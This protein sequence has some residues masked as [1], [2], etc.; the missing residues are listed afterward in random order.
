M[1][2]A[3][4]CQTPA[5]LCNLLAGGHCCD[6]LPRCRVCHPARTSEHSAPGGWRSPG[7]R[8][9]ACA[10]GCCREGR[11]RACAPASRGTARARARR[12]WKRAAAPRGFSSSRAS[13]K[14]WELNLFPFTVC[15]PRTL[16]RGSRLRYVKRV[17]RA[18]KRVCE[19]ANV[20]ACFWRLPS[21]AVHHYL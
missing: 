8:L 9:R 4:V 18:R 2:R 15:A 21:D 14:V 11:A 17:K 6:D 7:A 1:T 3:I 19:C 20:L 5:Q 13:V 16:L 12:A 10:L